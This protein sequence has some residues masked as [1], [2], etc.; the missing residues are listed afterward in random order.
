[1]KKNSL[2]FYFNHSQGPVPFLKFIS[3]HIK[4]LLY[5][6]IKKNQLLPTLPP[7]WFIFSIEKY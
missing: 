1:M 4:E 5:H 2:D 6:L 7:G 3:T